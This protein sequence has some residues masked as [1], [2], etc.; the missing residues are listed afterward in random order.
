MHCRVKHKLLQQRLLTALLPADQCLHVT[1]D[2]DVITNDKLTWPALLELLSSGTYEN[3]VISPGPGTPDCALDIGTSTSCSDSET[4][5]CAAHS[6]AEPQE[7]SLPLQLHMPYAG[8]CAELLKARLKLPI[9]GVCMGMQALAVAYGASIQ[10][11]PEPIHG[12]LSQ[13]EHTYHK[14]FKNIPGGKQ[15]SPAL[16]F[17]HAMT[18]DTVPACISIVHSMSL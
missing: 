5:S 11:A 1:A 13:I 8:V 15:C 3:V 2:P 6:C 17:S 4:V 14:L 16:H 9:L 7:W 18:T 10:H 12:R